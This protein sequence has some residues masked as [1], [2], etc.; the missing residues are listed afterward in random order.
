MRMPR[1]L[2][3][4]LV[5]TFF[6]VLATDPVCLAQ[7]GQGERA[8]QID[9]GSLLAGTGYKYEEVR[10]GLWR[11][12]GLPNHGKHVKSLIMYLEPGRSNSVLRLSLPLGLLRDPVETTEF[13]EK[14]NELNEKKKPTQFLLLKTALYAVTDLPTDNLDRDRVLKAIERLAND[15]DQSF[16]DLRKFLRIVGEESLGPGSGAGIG[17]GSGPGG[18]VKPPVL[19]IPDTPGNPGGNVARSVDSRPVPLNRVQPS[20]TEKARQNG[21]QGAVRMRMLIDETGTVKNI[22]VVRGLPDGL[23]EKAIEAGYRMKFRPA[24]KDGK[25]VAFWIVADAEFNLR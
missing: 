7:S 21:V 8:P 12:N 13:K 3:S 17:T 2:I 23:N 6:S 14:V 10:E 1:F 11:I 20:Y 5:F 15:A 4:L 19:P 9:V 25:P 16:N 24:M 22:I 18:S